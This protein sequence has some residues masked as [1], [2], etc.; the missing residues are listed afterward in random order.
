[1]RT[2]KNIGLIEQI[3]FSSGKINRI[4]KGLCERDYVIR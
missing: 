3:G 1:M 2:F 4:T